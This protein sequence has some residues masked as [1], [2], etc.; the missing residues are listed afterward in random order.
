MTLLFVTPQEITS[1][2]I[3][4]GNV[5][6]DKYRFCIENVQKTVIEPLLGTELYDKI[7]ADVT[8]LTITGDY[9]TL[10]TEYI[11]PITKNQAL[12]KYIQIAPFMVANGGI[13]KHSP[14]NAQIAEGTEVENLSKQYSGLA[15]IDIVRFEK[16][17][18]KNPLPEYKTHQDEVNATEVNTQFPWHL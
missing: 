8:N 18:G 13:F 6:I 17:I 2:T 15:E 1:T 12:A 5:D 7:I 4:G 10:Y 11:K 3:L 9:L 14:E 16:W